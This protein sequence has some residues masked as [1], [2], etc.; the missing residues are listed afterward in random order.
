MTASIS[1][2]LRLLLDSAPFSDVNPALLA[3][4]EDAVAAWQLDVGHEL[5]AE[6]VPMA[7]VVLVVEG[8]LRVSGRDAMG[9]PFTLRRVHAGEWWGLWSG[10]SGVS[11]ATCRT[12]ETTK[13]LAVPVELWRH[14]F[15]SSSELSKWL[16]SHPQREDIYAALRPLLAERPHKDRTYLDEIDHLQVFMRSVQIED[17]ETLQALCAEEVGTSWLMPSVSHLLPD[18]ERFGPEGLSITSLTRALKR[19]DYGLRLVGY[20]SEALEKLFDKSSS[21]PSLSSEANQ[22]EASYQEDLNVLKETPDWQNPDGEA[23]LAAALRNEQGQPARD[24]DGLKVTPIFGQSGVEQGLALLQ[25]ICETLRLP[26]RRDVVDRML[27]GMVGSKPSLA[28]KISAKS[29]MV[30]GSMLC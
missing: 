30:L 27:K 7:H 15:G 1:S 4:Q 24:T 21:S 16:E 12:T 8:T 26:F 5:A 13:L 11:A 20:P 3:A 17:L 10:L 18:L 23:L 29:L 9:T 19:S 2:R 22:V 14:W 6:N 28:L 25:M